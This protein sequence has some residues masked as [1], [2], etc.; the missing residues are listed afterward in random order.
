MGPIGWAQKASTSS[1]RPAV[2]SLFLTRKE[3]QKR[4]TQKRK[5]EEGRGGSSRRIR[6]Y[7]SLIFRSAAAAAPFLSLFS[8]SSKL[9]DLLLLF[10]PSSPSVF[11]YSMN[12]P[13]SKNLKFNLP[14]LKHDHG[15]DPPSPSS[16]VFDKAMIIQHQIPITGVLIL[17]KIVSFQILLVT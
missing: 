5:E 11:F 10:S 17:E 6:Y 3:R 9:S 13:S 16:D 12:A 1:T 4:K 15:L 14:D 7:V 8:C 2:R